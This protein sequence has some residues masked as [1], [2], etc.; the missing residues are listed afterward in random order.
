MDVKVLSGGKGFSSVLVVFRKELSVGSSQ[1]H[2]PSILFSLTKERGWKKVC[3]VGLSVLNRGGEL[4]FT[5]G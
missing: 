5:L 3:E 2:L 4:G 1:A